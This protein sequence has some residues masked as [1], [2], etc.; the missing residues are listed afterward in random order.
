M[1]TNGS[2]N[3]EESLSIQIPKKSWKDRIVGQR[4]LH[5]S[6]AQNNLSRQALFVQRLVRKTQNG[7]LGQV[8]EEPE[9][10][11]LSGD[12]EMN[13]KVGDDIVLQMP[14]T[15]PKSIMPSTVNPFWASLAT[16]GLLGAGYF[17]NEY[18]NKP[19]PPVVDQPPAVVTSPDTNTQYKMILE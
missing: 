5:D 8:T 12:D 3:N 14:D 13:F 18:L 10:K 7:T 4:I 2:Q 19:T 6:I 15:K 11:L 9:D 1:S 16:A 17:A